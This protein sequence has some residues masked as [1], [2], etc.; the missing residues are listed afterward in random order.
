[1]IET[2]DV[3]AF[4]LLRNKHCKIE[5]VVAA[6]CGEEGGAIGRLLRPLVSSLQ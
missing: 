5:I 3:A 1:M 2:G 4:C 6:S